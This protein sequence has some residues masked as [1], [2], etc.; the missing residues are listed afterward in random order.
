MQVEG[1]T[2]RVLTGDPPERTVP[3]D[4]EAV[5]P[6]GARYT[7]T[8]AT[9]GQLREIMDRWQTTGECLG[10][11]YLWVSEL[12]VVRDLSTQGIAAVVRDLIESD[13]VGAAMRLL[14]EL[15]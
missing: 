12:I 1:W 14:E 8:V 6:F 4:V 5:S 11:R 7:A 9:L 15:D 3:L 13:Q 10:G 2:V